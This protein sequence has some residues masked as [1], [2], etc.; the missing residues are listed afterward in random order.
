[1]LKKIFKTSL[2]LSIIILL[3]SV[4]SFANSDN[5]D[6][7]IAEFKK[8]Q[9]ELNLYLPFFNNL[10]TCTPY[11]G[12]VATIYD[13]TQNSCHFSIT[14]IAGEKDCNAPMEVTDLYSFY[15]KKVIKQLSTL[16]LEKDTSIEEITE[17][18]NKIITVQID[19][20]KLQQFEST[21]FKYHCKPKY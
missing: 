16:T 19:L 8:V 6:A 2:I 14:T 9:Q 13:K 20:A 21:V 1:M 15:G 17:N 7:K 5:I 18:L 3:C 4:K 10:E 12:K 11:K